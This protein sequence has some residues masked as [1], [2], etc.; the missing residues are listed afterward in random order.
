MLRE[1]ARTGPRWLAVFMANSEVVETQ[2]EE[3][4][5]WT[6]RRYTVWRK[7]TI[8]TL[9]MTILLP[10]GLVLASDVDKPERPVQP[11]EFG[12]GHRSLV[13]AASRPDLA[14]VGS[15][16]RCALS[17]DKGRCQVLAFPPRNIRW[18]SRR[19]HVWHEESPH[20]PATRPG[21]S[22]CPHRQPRAEVESDATAFPQGTG[23][24]GGSNVA[25]S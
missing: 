1:G 12:A 25:G 6:E 5:K 9:T 3:K 11:R 22:C 23:S 2:I 8:L 19:N 14:R 20:L 17:R 24:R 16:G 13:S 18:P 7:M 4:T 15:G 21:R 10:S